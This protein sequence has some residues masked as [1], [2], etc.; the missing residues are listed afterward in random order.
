LWI[1]IFGIRIQH[2]CIG[3]R[4]RSKAFYVRNKKQLSNFLKFFFFY[5]SYVNK[6]I[7]SGEKEKNRKR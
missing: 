5:I 1:R 6:E 3:S 2:Y 7:P 4:S